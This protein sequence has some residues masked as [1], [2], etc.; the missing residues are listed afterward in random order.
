VD[1]FDPR[2]CHRHQARQLGYDVRP[3]DPLGKVR[4]YRFAH[5]PQ[6]QYP[7]AGFKSANEFSFSGKFSKLSEVS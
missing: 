2:R 6:Q 5:K 7:T 4:R 1:R 3:A